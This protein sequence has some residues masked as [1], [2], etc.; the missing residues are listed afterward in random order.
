[1]QLSGDDDFRTRFLRES[2]TTAKLHDPHVIP[3]HD[4]GEVDGQLYLD[5]RIVRGDD[6]RALLRQGSLPAERAVDIVSQ[7]AGALDSAHDA[8]LTHRDVK[9]ENILLDKGGFAYL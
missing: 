4:Y 7:I 9:P 6:L 5:M 2:Q 8:G 3:I 1:P